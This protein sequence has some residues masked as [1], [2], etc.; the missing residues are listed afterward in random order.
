MWGDLEYDDE[1]EQISTLAYGAIESILVARGVGYSN[2]TGQTKE[3]GSYSS[4]GPT[5]LKRVDVY[6]AASVEGVLREIERRVFHMATEA[7]ASLQFGDE[8]AGVWGS[9][10]RDAEEAMQRLGVADHFEVIRSGLRSNNP[11][12]WR[13]AVF[14]CRSLI[15]DLADQL[16]QDP[17]P[18][19]DLL[20]G[21]ARNGR[22]PVERGKSKNRL[23]AYLHQK[24]VHGNRAKFL[25]AEL[26]RVADSVDALHDLT[27]SAHGQI[28]LVD[29]R[30]IA[31]ATYFAVAEICSRTDLQPVVEYT[32]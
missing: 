27:N 28:Q 16:W 2:V 5:V 12:E 8:I 19:Y 15:D 1:A 11:Q 26:G 25:V 3:L 7:Y 14:G 18:T 21:S 31:V 13:S 20:P 6:P 4:L 24:S 22:L 30:S 29:L 32:D 17:R 10:R 9:Y 23:R